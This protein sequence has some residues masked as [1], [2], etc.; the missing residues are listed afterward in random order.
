MLTEKIARRGL[1][2]TREYSTDPLETFFAREV[3]TTDPVVLTA[4]ATIGDLLP[5]AADVSS[6]GPVTPLYPVLD[7]TAPSPGWSPTA[8][9][10]PPWAGIRRAVPSANWPARRRAL[11]SAD[12]TLREVANAFAVSG[13]TRAPVV[14]PDDPGQLLGMVSLAQLLHARRTDHHEEHHRR[15]A[16]VAAHPSRDRSRRAA[17]WVTLS[18][19]AW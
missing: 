11:I 14:D 13:T 2:L 10:S 4:D 19:R 12:Q 8:S 3:M 16:P 15:A 1:H 5:A 17:L 9:C 18:G 7:A 6:S